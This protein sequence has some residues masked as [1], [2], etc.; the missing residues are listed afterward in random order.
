MLIENQIVKIMQI[1]IY[2]SFLLPYTQYVITA[3]QIVAE[4][5]KLDYVDEIRYVGS[6]VTQSA[7]CTN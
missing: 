4:N 6:L 3:M 2:V 5:P 7:Y 1:I